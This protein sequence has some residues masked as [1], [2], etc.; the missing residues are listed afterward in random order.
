MMCIAYTR[1]RA[2]LKAV[3]DESWITGTKRVSQGPFRSGRKSL[4]FAFLR[5]SFSHLATPSWRPVNDSMDP[6]I[7]VVHRARDTPSAAGVGA[8]D[9]WNG[10][11]RE[12]RR[13][14]RSDRRGSEQRAHRADA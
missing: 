7:R 6:L 4:D 5:S 9:R 1:R 12:R 2:R 13:A 10:D 8:G 11:R 3:W 14:A